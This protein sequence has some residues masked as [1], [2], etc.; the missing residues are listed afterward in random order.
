MSEDLKAAGWTHD[1]PSGF[2]GHTG[3]LWIRKH[4]DALQFGFVAEPMHSNRNG[5]VHG[6]MLMTFIDRAFGK[7]ARATTGASLAAT[8]SLTHQFMAPMKLGEFAT[9]TP[10]VPKVTSR[11]AFVE[12]TIF[13]GDRVIL[14]AQGIWR[15]SRPD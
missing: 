12:G 6:G 9:I 3:G 13:V 5:A 10:R 2:I 4:N 14:S 8:V 1:A 15:F 11:M 7:T